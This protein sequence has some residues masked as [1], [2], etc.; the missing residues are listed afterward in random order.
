MVPPVDQVL[1]RAKAQYEYIDIQRN[2]TARQRVLSIN[3]G[4]E[5][6]PTLVFPGGSTLTEPGPAALRDQLIAAGYPLTSGATLAAF[7]LGMLRSPT[8]LLLLIVI[9]LWLIPLLRDLIFG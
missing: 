8:Y 3:N 9:L 5:S 4:N 6:V 7:L 2:E 1:R